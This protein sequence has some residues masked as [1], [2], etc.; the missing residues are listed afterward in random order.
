MVLRHPSTGPNDGQKMAAAVLAGVLAAPGGI[1]AAPL[2]Q[3]RAAKAAAIRAPHGPGAPTPP[4]LPLAAPS[5]PEPRLP[6]AP[7]EVEAA[8]Q[9]IE[10]RGGVLVP[11]QLLDGASLHLAVAWRQRLTGPLWLHVE[12]GA[13]RTKVTALIDHVPVPGG[14]LTL[15]ADH[16]Q[17]TVPVL[18][19]LG[20][21]AE[22][23]DGAGFGLVAGVGPAITYAELRTSAPGGYALAT[24]RETTIDLMALGRVDVTW[25]VRPG[26]LVVGL[27]WQEILTDGGDRSTG[28]VRASGL[29]LEAGWRLGW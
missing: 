16:E 28:D 27:G 23:D 6:A 21:Q 8:D 26:L 14:A 2:D 25:S 10:A 1:A 19:G 20:L 22:P 7:P 15:R 3:V 29:I 9:A 4:A 17:W 24:K 13:D 12:S 11:S 18:G 5:L